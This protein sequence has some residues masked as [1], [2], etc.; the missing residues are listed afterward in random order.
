MDLRSSLEDVLTAGAGVIRA[1]LGVAV[2]ITTTTEMGAA[3][4]IGTVVDLGVLAV[5]VVANLDFAKRMVL[6][7]VDTVMADIR[8]LP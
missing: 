8:I 1:D 3:I 7:T 4:V 5:P 6:D 2:M